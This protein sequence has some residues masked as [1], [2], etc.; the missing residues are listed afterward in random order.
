MDIDHIGANVQLSN[1]SP[2]NDFDME[3]T[4]HAEV[5]TSLVDPS[6]EGSSTQNEPLNENLLPHPQSNGQPRIYSTTFGLLAITS[7]PHIGPIFR[8]L[9]PTWHKLW[10]HQDLIV[11]MGSQLGKCA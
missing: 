7:K 10:Y 2:T 11:P 3:I 9:L 6:Q 8:R 5:E 1:L 4:T